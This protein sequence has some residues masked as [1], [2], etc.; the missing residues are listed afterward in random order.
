VHRCVIGLL[1]VAALLTVGAGGALM[2]NLAR[3][4]DNLALVEHDNEA[5]RQISS[6]EAG[7]SQAESSERGWI[8][9]GN[10]S[11]LQAYH[12]AAERVVLALGALDSL[13]ADEPGQAHRLRDLRTMIQS[14]L[15]AFA[16]A[17]ELGPARREEA[18]AVLAAE[19]QPQAA[20]TVTGAFET[21]RGIET[22][23]LVQ[24]KSS[25]DR[26][27]VYTTVTASAMALLAILGAALGAYLLQRERTLVE[28]R[29]NKTYL[30]A[31]LAT[32]PDAMIAFDQAGAIESFS[33]T[34]EQMFQLHAEEARGRR[35]SS[36][37]SGQAVKAFEVFMAQFQAGE[38]RHP[39]PREFVAERRD[40]SNFPAELNVS[41]VL[42]DGHVRFIAFIRDLSERQ[43]RERQAE[44]L[45]GELLHFSRL[46]NMGEMAA[47]LA[48]EL[49][50]PLTALSAYLQGAALLL[51]Q[52]DA[53]KNDLV[54]A[55]MQKATAQAL[56]ASDVIRRLREFVARGE[57][58][59]HIESLAN[60]VQ[61]AC[62]LAVIT[63]REQSVRFEVALDPRADLVLVNKVQIQ[64]VLLNLIRNAIEAMKD[65]ARHE[66]A[67]RSEPASNGM[68]RVS[69]SDTGSGISP[70]VATRLFQSFVTTKS[71]G[72]GVGLSISRT[73]V[74]AHG[75]RISVEPNPGGGTVFRITLRS[76]V[77]KDDFEADGNNGIT[78]E[79]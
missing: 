64:Q 3:F 17:V 28:L 7:L 11:Y 70:D 58:D 47:A 33:A 30:E 20:A 15:D 72:L 57:T 8:L 45:R 16:R 9:S 48:H 51:S 4:R 44:K 1:L 49:N 66:L 56:R 76:G 65:S 12:R 74:E 24:R 14:R 2:L 77:L 25:A 31:I 5:L 41:N 19:R 68:V 40:G 22:D 63:E 26:A 34:A 61:E 69:V 6:A 62:A 21:F 73:I 35:I 71:G 27:A 55:A 39:A 23:L 75:G 43:A 13:T 32:V 46:I 42:S 60:M 36:L 54:I 59:R 38:A 29:A 67:I 78:G 18:L 53:E 50:Q 52:G 79:P 10:A 37:F